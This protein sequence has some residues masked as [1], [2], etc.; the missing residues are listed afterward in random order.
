[1]P[2]GVGVCLGVCVCVRACVC[3]CV[4]GRAWGRA[5]VCV[6]LRRMPDVCSI[7]ATWAAY[8]AAQDANARRRCEV[9][10]E[11]R[12]RNAQLS[13]LHAEAERLG[14]RLRDLTYRSEIQHPDSL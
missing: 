14:Q 8:R 3:V 10:R 6:C 9:A 12:L 4:R 5:R 7:R 2:L 11:L 1:M 13:V